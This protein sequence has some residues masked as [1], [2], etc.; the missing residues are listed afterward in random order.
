MTMDSR[1]LPP[2]NALQHDGAPAP[3]SPSPARPAAERQS[4]GGRVLCPGRRR[5]TFPR[6]PPASP[7]VRKVVVDVA[8]RWR[9]TNLRL[10]RL[11]LGLKQREEGTA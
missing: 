11:A 8:P 2:N 1:K 9:Q 10:D 6:A 4:F 7:G 5:S 3:R